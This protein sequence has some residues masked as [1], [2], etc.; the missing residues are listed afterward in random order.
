M[1]TDKAELPWQDAPTLLTY[2]LH[3]FLQAGIVPVVVLGPHNARLRHTVPAPAQVAINPDP[4][5][6][7]VS[8]IQIGLDSLPA[9]LEALAMGSARPVVAIAAVDQPRSASI[10]RRLLEAHRQSAAPITAPTY[11]QQLGHPLFFSS[12]LLPQLRSLE[13][14]SQGL[15]RLVREYAAVIQRVE[16]ETAE[17]LMDLNRPDEYRRAFVSPEPN[18]PSPFR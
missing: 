14:A 18:F 12:Q 15:R 16:F 2:Q 3:Q 9:E 17:V 1:G 5:R 13:E 7:K 11:R 4:S 6:G 8:S 10:L